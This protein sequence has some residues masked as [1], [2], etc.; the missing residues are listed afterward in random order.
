MTDLPG[1]LLVLSYV[2]LAVLA[3]RAVLRRRS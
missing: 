1:L 3:A 2:L